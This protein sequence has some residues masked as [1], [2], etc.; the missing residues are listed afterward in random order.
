MA[1]A[2]EWAWLRWAAW[3]AER[4]A[5]K[6]AMSPRTHMPESVIVRHQ[7]VVLQHTGIVLPHSG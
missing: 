1:A 6:P 4:A 2:T 3:S 7:A 5:P